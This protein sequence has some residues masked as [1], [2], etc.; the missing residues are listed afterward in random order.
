MKFL[1]FNLAVVGALF[2]LF[3]VDRSV[4]EVSHAERDDPLLAIIQDLETMA[5]DFTDNYKSTG[6]DARRSAEVDS[7]DPATGEKVGVAD[8][9][10][11]GAALI[12]DGPGK[13]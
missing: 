9:D 4:P 7:V 5:R 8:P 12:P 13:D 1:L 6:Q 10:W 11:E 2:Y 3:T